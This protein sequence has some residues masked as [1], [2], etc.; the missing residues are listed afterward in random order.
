MTGVCDCGAVLREDNT[1]GRCA[2][3]AWYAR[4]DRLL[5][6]EREHQ[7]QRRRQVVAQRLAQIDQGGQP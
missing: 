5:A 6:I 1:T 2:E 3:C 7:Q 4:N